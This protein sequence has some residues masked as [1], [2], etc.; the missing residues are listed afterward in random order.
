MD[1]PA[2]VTVLYDTI[3]LDA[4][5]RLGNWAARVVSHRRKEAAVMC[6]LTDLQRTILR[7]LYDTPATVD[8]LVDRLAVIEHCA[9]STGPGDS[10]K[11][12]IGWALAYL[13]GRGLVVHAHVVG[14]TGAETHYLLTDPGR[15]VARSGPG[16]APQSLVGWT[17][18][19][20]DDPGVVAGWAAHYSPFN[21]ATWGARVIPPTG[22]AV[23][24]VWEGFDTGNGYAPSWT[25]FVI[26]YGDAQRAADALF[27]YL[28]RTDD[29][30]PD[31]LVR[32]LVRA[33]ATEA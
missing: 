12:Q 6:D 27:P 3:S 33:G 16:A 5:G 1:Q 19:I 20:S 21:P 18:A 10:W 2:T 29:P 11:T 14:R 25:P 4:A 31:D 7:V 15:D 30:R 9:P 28:N 22:S 17:V 26:A 24:V 8:A 32:A 23:T 13:T